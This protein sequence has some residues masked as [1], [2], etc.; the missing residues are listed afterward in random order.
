MKLYEFINAN[1]EEIITEWET[2]AHT[3]TPAAETMSDG[4]LRDHAKEIL[5]A[6]VLDI[7]TTQNPV[8]QAEKSKGLAADEGDPHS[9]A[10]VHGALR[11]A[12]SFSL[13]QLSAEFRA[14][15]ATVL[16][17]W[18]PRVDKASMNTVEE[19]VR[20][21]EAID[22]TLAES[23][24]TYS[25]K[26][27]ETRDLFLAVLGHDLRA[28][29]STMTLAGEMLMREESRPEKMSK[30][31][32]KVRRSALLMNNMVADLLGFTRTQLGK[33]MPVNCK[34]S[35]LADVCKAALEDARATHPSITFEFNTSGNLT[36]FFDPVRLHQLLTNLL[37]NAG[38][39]C[40]PKRPVVLEA[41]GGQHD[42]TITVLNH[43]AAVSAD[44][45]ELIFK[46]LVQLMADGV[47]D[48]RPK[49]SLGL[50]L[51]IAREIAV[52]HGGTINVSSSATEGT[53]F[54]ARLP[55][56]TSAPV[57]TGRK[58]DV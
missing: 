19:M 11:Q 34:Q 35:N 5:R 37:V 45:L 23:I 51:F 21:N 30:I 2:F 9:A 26:T 55:R 39:Y 18:L 22:Q 1:I 12:S 15:R 24:V 27:D 6:I 53:V 3:L 13:L 52:A 44:A 41:T 16:R 20:F 14:L 32:D 58:F 49:T 29:L 4:A 38:Q 8:Q 25:A 36:A 56:R 17:L 48:N 47:D 28:P 57:D 54:T 31:G 10:S 42:L 43:G 7:E 40:T 33:G 50:G 46:P